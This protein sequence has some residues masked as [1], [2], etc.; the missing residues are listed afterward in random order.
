MTENFDEEA[1]SN[2]GGVK[3]VKLTGRDLEDARRLLSLF[4][5]NEPI[6]VELPGRSAEG[7]VADRATLRVRAR[8]IL[9]NRRL[10]QEV[11]G[12]SMFSE[13]AWE[14]LLLLYALDT[15][16]RQSVNRLSDLAGASRTTALR[17]IE[18]LEQQQL[19][20]RNGHPT[21]RRVVFLGLTDKAREQIE[22]YLCRIVG[23]AE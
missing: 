17:W 2:P 7:S 3:V 1:F 14:M 16:Q 22:L 20:Q 4:V 18:Y 19:I 12:K 11:F 13:P 9:A 21:D 5:R 23:H 15:G 8:E 10:R 6:S